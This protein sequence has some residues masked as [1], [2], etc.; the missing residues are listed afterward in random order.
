MGLL[1]KASCYGDRGQIGERGIRDVRIGGQLREV[2]LGDDQ[3]EVMS[4]FGSLNT[5]EVTPQV[6]GLAFDPHHLFRN[7]RCDGLGPPLLTN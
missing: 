6:R 4:T 7:E 5:H 2:T 3:I 1:A